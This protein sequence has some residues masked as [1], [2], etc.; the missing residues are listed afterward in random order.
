M[1]TS[2]N[3]PDRDDRTED[4]PTAQRPA[5]EPTQELPLPDAT[6]QLPVADATTEPPRNGTTAVTPPTEPTETSASSGTTDEAPLD[7][8]TAEFASDS[9]SGDRTGDSTGA[10][11]GVGDRAPGSAIPSVTSEPATAS[12]GAPSGQPS[13]PRTDRPSTPPVWTASSSVGTAPDTAGPTTTLPRTEAPARGVQVGQLIWAGIVILLGVFL[14]ALALL[15]NLDVTTAL[16]GLV[17]L[18]GVALI[19]AAW[20]TSRRPKG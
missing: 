13:A 2:E 6:A 12:T 3:T 1:T 5:N 10:N 18:L 15:P 4:A 17:A 16:I 19:I 7:W 11:G 14:I 8:R 20:A 9:S